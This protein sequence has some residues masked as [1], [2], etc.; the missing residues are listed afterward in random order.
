MSYLLCL[1]LSV[2]RTG[3]LVLNLYI[4]AEAGE[5]TGRQH[6][7]SRAPAVRSSSN[8]SS[9]NRV[10]TPAAIIQQAV[11]PLTCQW[12]KLRIYRIVTASSESSFRNNQQQSATATATAATTA[13]TATTATGRTR[14]MMFDPNRMR[15]VVAAQIVRKTTAS[16][17][18]TAT[19]VL[20]SPAVCPQLSKCGQSVF[21]VQNQVDRS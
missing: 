16:T 15:P 1:F 20:V 14:R 18:T 8:S 21:F 7:N 2:R 11:K 4:S 13:T 10:A 12:S 5:Q 17:A 3:R 9:S 19:M 6:Q